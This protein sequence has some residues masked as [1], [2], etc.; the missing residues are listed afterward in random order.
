MLFTRNTSVDLRCSLSFHG[1]LHC[2]QHLL[3]FQSQQN[4]ASTSSTRKLGFNCVSQQT[5][6]P[7]L[8]LSGD[9][10]QNELSIPILASSSSSSLSPSSPS[11]L[12]DTGK[13]KQIMI[14]P[15]MAKIQLSCFNTERNRRLSL[16][17]AWDH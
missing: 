15:S 5:A 17:C 4:R 2:L 10:P 12:I 11:S 16:R 13:F 6:S 3:L 9:R 14:F 7:L 8:D 1:F